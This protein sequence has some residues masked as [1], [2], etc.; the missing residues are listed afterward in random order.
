M[1]RQQ[2][3]TRWE[4]AKSKGPSTIIR[5]PMNKSQMHKPHNSCK[6]KSNYQE[7]AEWSYSRQMSMKKAKPNK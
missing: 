2:A 5:K 7:T 6:R 3:E 4:I 1:I